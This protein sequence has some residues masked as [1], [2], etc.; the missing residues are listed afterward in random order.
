MTKQLCIVSFICTLIV[1]TSTVSLAQ[2]DG[3]RVSVANMSQ[4]I[5]MLVQQVKT[6]HLEVE[7][8]Q[9]ENNRLRAQ[10]EALSSSGGVNAQIAGLEN[11]I[12]RLRVEFRQA[13]E[14]QKTKIINEVSRQIKALGSEMQTALNSVA[15]VVSSE[16]RV[17][18]PV[19]FSNDYPKT[20]K[21]YVVRRGDTLSGIA[22]DHGSTVKD[23]QNANKIVNPA[24]DLQVGETIFIPI[25]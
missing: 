15:K 22:R 20:G 8:L 12:N 11:T 3:L 13:D 17:E 10:M 14:I 1:S 19:H 25:P 24:R 18:V 21:P 7:A 16:P 5:S 6:L 9:R 2:S 4:D 23:I